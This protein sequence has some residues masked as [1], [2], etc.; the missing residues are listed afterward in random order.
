MSIVVWLPR[1]GQ[2]F[3]PGKPAAQQKSHSYFTRWS[4]QNQESLNF[5]EKNLDLPLYKIEIS[6]II[7][8]VRCASVAQSVEQGTENPRVIGSIPIGGT[9]SKV[10]SFIE[11]S[12]K[13]DFRDEYQTFS[14][15]PQNLASQ[16]FAGAPLKRTGGCKDKCTE[17]AAVAHL[18]ER[19]LAKVEVASSS[20]VGRSIGVVFIT[21]YMVTW[22]SGKAR[23][24][25]TLIHQFK[26]GRHLQKIPG[27]FGFRDFL[28]CT[29]PCRR[30]RPLSHLR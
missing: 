1:P 4:D 17:Y 15:S 19:H 25:K 13:Q 3:P 6:G 18:V 9:T 27:S 2:C 12:C 11:K 29:V 5:I 20:L 8:I 23:V 22:P 21:P 10:L 16:A 14:S 26:S 7:I 28:F 24:C 30:P